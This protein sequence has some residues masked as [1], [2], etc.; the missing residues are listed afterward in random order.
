[1]KYSLSIAVLVVAMFAGNAFADQGQVSQTQLS[2][3]GLPAGMTVLSDSQGEEIRGQGFAFAGSISASALPG[4]FN[5]DVAAALGAHGAFAAT[6]S[7][8]SA[9]LDATVSILGFPVFNIMG[10]AQVGSAG[11]AAA[12]SY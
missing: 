10:S 4:T 12:A 9:S 11:F 1:M 7:T 8:S 6:G 2:E 3:L 5:A